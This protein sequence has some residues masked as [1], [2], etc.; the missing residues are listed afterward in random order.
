MLARETALL[1]A[2]FR[3]IH[4][5]R[6]HGFALLVTLGNQ[7]VAAAAASRAL[8]EGTEQAAELRHPE[9]AAAWLRARVMGLLPREPGRLTRATE[10]ARRASLRALGVTDEVFDALA[11]LRTVPRA[12]LVATAI[13]GLDERDVESIVGIHG[14]ALRAAIRR[15]RGSYI[16]VASAAMPPGGGATQT[17]P[18]SLTASI[19]EEAQ[20]TLGAREPR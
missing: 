5:Q 13:E 9:R 19:E 8:R 2:A 17:L 1:Q 10:P 14:H 15:A 7:S 20:R 3:D 6:L 11:S 12:T 4:G 18:G 16:A